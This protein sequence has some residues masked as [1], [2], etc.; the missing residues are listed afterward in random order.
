MTTPSNAQL[1][2]VLTTSQISTI[3]VALR[4]R[5]RELVEQRSYNVGEDAQGAWLSIIDDQ[6]AD[7]VSAFSLFSDEVLAPR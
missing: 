1:S 3:S 4:V 6:L 2:A 7:V 5:Y